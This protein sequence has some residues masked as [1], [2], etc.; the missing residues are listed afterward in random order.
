MNDLFQIIEL[1]IAPV[2]LLTG[3]GG[4]LNVMS[5]RLGRVVDRARV[6]EDAL[7][8]MNADQSK[9][10]Q[11]ELKVLWRRIGLSNWSIWL[12]TF[13]GLLVCVLVM[14]LFGA[15]LTPFPLEMVVES[16][17]VAALLMLI[18]SLSTFLLEIRLATKTLRSG[19]ESRFNT[20][21]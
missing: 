4:I 13:S 12:C 11:S 6:V 19:K 2:F 1:S 5:G 8:K 17:F 20:Q 10:A 18:A 7:P 15:S 9:L 3:I 16:L 14:S 21:D